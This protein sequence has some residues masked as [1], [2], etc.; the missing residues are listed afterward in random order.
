MTIRPNDTRAH[1]SP[2]D[3][4]RASDSTRSQ[5]DSHR[6]SGSRRPR[7]SRGQPPSKPAAAAETHTNGNG[8]GVAA[9]RAKRPLRVSIFGMGY[10]GT[11]SAGCLARM[12]LSVIGLDANAT[13]VEMLAAGRSPVIEPGLAE[14]IS[15][16]TAQKR[17]SVS[18]DAVQAV[19]DTDI[20]LYC[21]GTPGHENGGLNLDAVRDVCQSIGA[22][23][24]QKNS[25]HV[26]RPRTCCRGPRARS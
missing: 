19:R 3:G 18:T 26:V 15:G 14:L 21:V 13:K 4:D 2:D 5:H 8:N 24:R 12:G 16:G 11:V 17:I 6:I 1:H 25:F 7:C 20:T 22:A 23:L 9:Q 10:V